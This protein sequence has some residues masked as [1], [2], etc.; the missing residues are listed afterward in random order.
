MTAHR[1]GI[2]DNGGPPLD[3]PAPASPPEPPRLASDAACARC[4][5]WNPPSEREEADYRAWKGGYGRR[6]KEPSGHC[7]RVMH[8]PGGPVSFAGTMG[9]SR[10]FNYEAKPPPATDV[11][12]RGF[13]TIWGPGD[14]IL[15]QGREGEEPAEFRQGELGL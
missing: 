5:H 14:K 4:L 8:R 1:P 15:W 3:D 7:F 12:G 9:R 2:G 6:V 13:V 10:C 11:R